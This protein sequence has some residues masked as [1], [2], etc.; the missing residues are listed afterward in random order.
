MEHVGV[1]G[2]VCLTGVSS[3]GHLI[4]VDQGTLNRSMVL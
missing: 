3:G 1:G 2:V 4:D